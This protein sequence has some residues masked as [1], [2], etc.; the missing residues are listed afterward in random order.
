MHDVSQLTM[1]QIALIYYRK[2]DKKGVP[3]PIKSGRKKE[4]DEKEMFFK[5]GRDLGMSDESLK[6]QWESFSG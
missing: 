5:M 3:R 6:S 1:R 4:F 2:R